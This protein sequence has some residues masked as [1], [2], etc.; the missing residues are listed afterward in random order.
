MAKNTPVL[1]GKTLAGEMMPTWVTDDQLRNAG[2]FSTV[3][4]FWSD[5]VVTWRD[6]RD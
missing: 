6:T 3:L 1:V 2:V 5:G 4:Y